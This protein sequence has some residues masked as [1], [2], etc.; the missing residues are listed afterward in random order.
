MVRQVIYVNDQR[1]VEVETTL[2]PADLTPEGIS[3]SRQ[4]EVSPPEEERAPTAEMFLLAGRSQPSAV[5]K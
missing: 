1:I 5:V 3:P 4:E 2:T